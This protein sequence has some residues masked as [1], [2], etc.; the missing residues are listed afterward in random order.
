MAE[1]KLAQNFFERHREKIAFAG[2][3][4]CWLWMAGKNSTG[5]G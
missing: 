4:E 5:Y 1:D 2:P 3:D